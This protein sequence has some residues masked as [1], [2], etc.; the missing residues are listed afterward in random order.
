MKRKA[1]TLIELLV[2]IA[3]IGILAAIALSA[4]QNARKRAQDARSKSNAQT[5]LKG[6]VTHS[7]DNNGFL[8]AGLGVA[9]AHLVIATAGCT[10]MA[11]AVEGSGALRSGF[12]AAANPALYCA[13]DPD[14]AAFDATSF[15]A[16]AVGVG[17]PL[18]VNA[19]N[20]AATNTY[21]LP[22]PGSGAVAAPGVDGVFGTPA[23]PAGTW[24]GWFV[25][26]QK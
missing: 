10:N 1:F 2:V 16:S 8:N 21:G 23:Y 11:A 15:T 13:T 9:A 12:T 24:A 17:V 4:T 6:V 14:I 7:S 25:V 5:W 3:I 18:Q 26:T 22:S 19:V 20:S